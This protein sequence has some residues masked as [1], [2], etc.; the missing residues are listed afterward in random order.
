[1]LFV[2]T[3]YLGHLMPP[4]FFKDLA[5]DQMNMTKSWIVKG[6]FMESLNVHMSKM[7]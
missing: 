4:S 1:M 6:P 5:V 3:L 2:I 7:L